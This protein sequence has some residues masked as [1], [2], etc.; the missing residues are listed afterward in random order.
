MTQLKQHLENNLVAFNRQL[1]KRKFYQIMLTSLTAVFP[2]AAVSAFTALIDKTIFIPTG[3]FEQLYHVSKWLP[4]Y[5][6][7]G[8]FW[9]SVSVL[10]N[11]LVVV[12]LTF[13]VAA[14]AAKSKRQNAWLAGIVSST[15]LWLC[16]QSLFT[17]PLKNGMLQLTLSFN[18]LTI[19]GIFEAIV[20]GF[21]VSWFLGRYARHQ[22]LTITL[23]ILV[24]A[25]I[26]A[27]LQTFSPNSL[28]GV[29]VAW[30]AQVT[31][32][33]GKNIVLLLVLGLI[34][35]FL[36]I[37]GIPGS[38]NLADGSNDAIFSLQNLNY[39]LQHH[40]LANVP[41]PVNLHALYDTY[42]FVGGSGMLLA[43]LIAILWRTHDQHTQHTAAI[44]FL[45]TFFN[46][47]SPILIGMPVL[48]NPLLVIPFVVA[49][50][51]ACLVAW[52]FVSLHWMPTAVY[53]VPVTT[54]GILKGFLATGGNWVALLV[55]VLNLGLATLIYLPFVTLNDQ[56]N[57][58]SKAGER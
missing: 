43:L 2:I 55:S 16:N 14:N 41:Y 37:L 24:V 30:F 48:F 45:P 22:L 8:N 5:M 42:A 25:A 13:L 49:P 46:L 23:L 4:F 32:N 33:W 28:V 56:Y 52:L 9:A 57:L 39:A 1:N 17:E 10:L 21:C 29:L 20:L 36:L 26:A 27:G 18:G 40:H 15:L 58:V 12:W 47:N 11:N 53:P 31:A 50:L 6:Q 44:S 35:N 3:F 19:H 34:S 51:V 7:V 38:L 54:P